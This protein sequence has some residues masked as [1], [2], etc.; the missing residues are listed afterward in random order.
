MTS[1]VESRAIK[2]A[3]PDWIDQELRPAI[4]QGNEVPG[5]KVSEDGLVVS[6]KRF[7]EGLPIEWQAVGP[8]NHKYP[9]C[10]MYLPRELVRNKNGIGLNYFANKVQRK[11]PIHALVIS[12]WSDKLPKEYAYPSEL[13]PWWDDF[14]DK[15][16]ETLKMYFQVD[17]IDSNRHNPH[18]TNLRYVSSRTNNPY[19]KEDEKNSS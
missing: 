11:V 4:F 7:P 9:A 16:R 18:I 6:F 12:T 17:H 5:Y 15:L 1:S 8:V 19:N 10:T 13:E 14:D 2:N 3:R